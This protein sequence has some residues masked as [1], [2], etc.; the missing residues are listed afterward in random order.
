M[1]TREELKKM[2]P[3]LDDFNFEKIVKINNMNGF[4]SDDKMS[5]QKAY[6]HMIRSFY[7]YKDKMITLKELC[8][9]L[10]NNKEVLKIENETVFTEREQ[11]RFTLILKN[12]LNK[13]KKRY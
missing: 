9:E 10:V 11:K 12:I 13:I 3:K 1:K 8:E 7:T 2:Y 5:Q 4:L 6:N